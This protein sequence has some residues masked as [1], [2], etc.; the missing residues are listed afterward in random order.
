MNWR[1]TVRFAFCGATGLAFSAGQPIGIITS[2]AFPAVALK[3]NSR[4]EA[5]AAAASY[6]G[7]AS[8][9]IIVASRNF[10]GP[11]AGICDGILL[12]LSAVFL[13][14][15]PW[16]SLWT[17]RGR[18]LFW[19]AQLSVLLTVAPPLGLIGWASPLTAAG[20]LFPSTSWLGLVSVVLAIGSLASYPRIAVPAIV[21][22][23][24]LA[25]LI[26]GEPGKQVPWV[27]INTHFGGISHERTSALKE[28]NAVE[29]IQQQAFVSEAHVVIFPEAVV[30]NWGVA[31]D[32]FLSGSI[33]ELRKAGKTVIIGSK[34][35]TSSSASWFSP[36]DFAASVAILQA[37]SLAPRI[38]IAP[39]SAVSFKNV[40]IVRGTDTGVFEQRVPVPLGM[41]KPLSNRG[42]PLRPFS[43]GVLSVAGERAGVLICYEQLLTWPML[44]SMLA[45]PTVLVAVA[46]DYWEGGTTIPNVQLTAVRAW[47]RLNSIPYVSATNF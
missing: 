1:C 45:R 23:A 18:Q 13:L 26:Y 28:L 43:P 25:N 39:N 33:A 38:P 9:P 41:W 6:Y 4:R 10:F 3:A 8:W 30:R 11:N 2:V 29:A 15:L 24:A 22:V 27:G 12:W 19:R 37:R 14:S 40:L 5:Y 20:Y 16:L 7:G 31:T 44:T 32:S 35:E 47:A 42:V 46:N 36:A 34:I 17:D 21:S